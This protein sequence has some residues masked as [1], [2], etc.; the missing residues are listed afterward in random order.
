[1]GNRGSGLNSSIP[2]NQVDPSRL[3]L[4]PLLGR[5][6]TSPEVIAAGFGQPYDGFAAQF[7]TSA[8]LAQALR[9]YPQFLNVTHR[10]SGDG[11]V[12]YDAVQAKLERRFGDLQFNANYTY[13][14]SL[15]QLHFRQIFTQF[16]TIAQNAYDL[17]NEKSM[18]PFDLPHKF[19]VLAFIDMPFGRGKRYFGSSNRGTD[20]LVGGWQVGVILE[21]FSGAVFAANA[22]NT[23]G[24]GVLFAQSR[25]PHLGSQAIRT[26]IDRTNLDPGNPDARWF[27]PGAF[28]VP[29][30]AFEFG[31][32]SRY[33]SDFRQPPFF[34]DNFSIVKR[35]NMFEVREL[36]IRTTIRADFFNAFNRTNFGVNGA[37]GN[38]AF[39]RATGPQQGARIITMGLRVEF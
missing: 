10:N 17:G 37:I 29:T 6:I 14:K 9:P 4:G 33:I 21:Y 26:G 7:G 24:N 28:V 36:P 16:E 30:N 2:I 8:T 1:L 39:G 15:S 34:R 27:N 31:S 20:L 22:P 23:L 13:S 11:K 25:R 19:N 12:W 32:A 38:A 18:S 35:F 3:G 5:H